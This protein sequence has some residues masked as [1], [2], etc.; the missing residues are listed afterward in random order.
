MAKNKEEALKD[1]VLNELEEELAEEETKISPLAL[2]LG[3][4]DLNALVRK[5]NELVEKVNK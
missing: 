1:E 4:E 2:D 3:R 5:V